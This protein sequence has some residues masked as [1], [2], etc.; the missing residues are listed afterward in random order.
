MNILPN[1][2]INKDPLDHP[3]NKKLEKDS[4]E[5]FSPVEGRRYCTDV[6]FLLL[7]VAA[8]VAMTGIGLASTGIIKSDIIKKGD[9]NRLING[10]RCG[11]D[12]ASC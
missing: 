6:L 12:S 8:W 5:I 7:L 4:D 10:K 9:P 11:A 3:D 1:F 2:K